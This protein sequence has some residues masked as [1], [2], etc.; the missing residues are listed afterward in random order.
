MT[1]RTDREM[2]VYSAILS[3]SYVVVAKA[4]AHWGLTALDCFRAYADS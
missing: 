4:T 1:G 2:T 3:S